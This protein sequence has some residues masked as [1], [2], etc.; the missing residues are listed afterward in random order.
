[1]PWTLTLGSPEVR[2]VFEIPVLD[3]TVLCFLHGSFCLEQTMVCAVLVVSSVV[4]HIAWCGLTAP[5]WQSLSHLLQVKVELVQ[6][7]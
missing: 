3:C 1:M 6:V 4:V 7:L 2:N 5:V